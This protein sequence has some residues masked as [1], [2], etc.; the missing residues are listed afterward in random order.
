MVENDSIKTVK[1]I[2]CDDE[3][4]IATSVKN[5][6]KK[7]SQDL[8]VSIETEI[9]HSAVDCLYKIFKDYFNGRRYDI[10]LIDETM[11]F[12]KGSAL[13]K[14][15]KNIISSRELNNILIYSIT[16]Y[17]DPNTLGNIK[18]EGCDGFLKKPV[19]FAD[20]KNLTESFI[21]EKIEVNK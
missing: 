6:A 2:I 11:P 15:L 14:L 12:M 21:N 10:L 16:G 20:L 1:I 3:P 9:T 19:R 7:V 18:K 8:L 17:E 4:C 5:L 13:I